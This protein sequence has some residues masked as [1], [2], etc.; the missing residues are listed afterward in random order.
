MSARSIGIAVLVASFAVH[1]EDNPAARYR[2]L[3]GPDCAGPHNI[4]AEE[5]GE[6][7][8][9]TFVRVQHMGDPGSAELLGEVSREVTWDVGRMTGLRAPSS[10]Q[11]GYRDEPPPVAASAFHL[12]CADARKRARPHAR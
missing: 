6:P 10:A 8:N 5:A 9:A 3:S 2:V 11:R 4:I 12:A 7:R 1:G